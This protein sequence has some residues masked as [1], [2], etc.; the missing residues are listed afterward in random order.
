MDPEQIPGDAIERGGY[1]YRD[2][3]DGTPAVVLVGTGS[4]VA[5]CVAAAELLEADGVNARVVSMPCVERFLAQPAEYRDEIL[6]PA[7]GARLSVE[8]GSTL[9]WNRVVG[10][11]GASVGI[12]HFGASAPASVLAEKFGFTPEAVA[13]RAREL[14]EA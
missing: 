2:P 10:N 14:V 6:P 5:I 7:I 11:S 1:V 3:D 4:E 9:G 13:A 12:D 8:A